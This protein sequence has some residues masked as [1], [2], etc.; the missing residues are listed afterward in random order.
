ML[1]AGWDVS[2]HSIEA[3]QWRAQ[4][5]TSTEKS[6]DDGVPDYVRTKHSKSE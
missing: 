5:K 1:L 2:T 6:N 4:W 3:G